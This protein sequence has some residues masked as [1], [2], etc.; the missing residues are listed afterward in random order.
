VQTLAIE[1][2]KRIHAIAFA[3]GG[4]ELAAIC[5]DGFLRVW[6]LGTG[7]VRREARITE[8]AAGYDL[9]Y[10]GSDRLIYWGLFLYVWDIATDKWREVPSASHWGRRLKLSPD[11][12]HL[13]EVDQ[14]RSTDFA[15]GDGLTVR[16]TADWELVPGLPWTE[17]TTGGV[18]FSSDGRF[19]ATAHMASVG[20]RSRTITGLPGIEFTVHNYDYRVLVRRWPGGGVPHTIDGW[21]QAVT[22]L[23]FSLDGRFLAGTAGPRL[24]VWDLESDREVALHKRG[25]KHFQ[26]LSF[27][28]D[29]RFLATV[30]NDETVRVWDARTWA[31]HTTFTWKVGR[32]LNISF[33]PD[34]LRAAAGS[35]RGQIVIWDVE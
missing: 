14:T 21:Q 35:D 25:P 1:K 33:A 28:R 4:E 6:D 3:P 18:A 13:A 17:N 30:S 26:G 12:Q 34:G 2:K 32:L 7:Q 29:G 15:A 31:E 23:A 11:G 27:T 24:R 16:T 19:L 10:L 22:H 8:T 9:A 5:G 20:Q